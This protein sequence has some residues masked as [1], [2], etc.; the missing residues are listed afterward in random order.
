MNYSR[1][2]YNILCYAP[3][4]WRNF[5]LVEAADLERHA[6]NKEADI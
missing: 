6:S 2:K 1:A 5:A 3:V 4:W